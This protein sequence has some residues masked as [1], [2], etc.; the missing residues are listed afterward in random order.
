MATIK[1]KNSSSWINSALIYY[2][3]GCVYISYTNITPA[4]LFGGTWSTI[5]GYFPYFNA[6]TSTG[7]SNTHTLSSNEM[8]SHTHKLVNI[9]NSSDQTDR[10]IA[11]RSGSTSTSGLQTVNNGIYHGYGFFTGTLEDTGGGNAHNNMPS[12]Q[13]LYAWRRTA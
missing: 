8:P 3:V 2:P 4:D 10:F 9:S 6:G 13:T 5:T 11:L 7:G 1:Y 12:Y